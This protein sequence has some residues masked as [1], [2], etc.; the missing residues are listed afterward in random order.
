MSGHDVKGVAA[1]FIHQVLNPT[2]PADGSGRWRA[3]IPQFFFLAAGIGFYLVVRTFTEGAE[4]DAFRNAYSILAFEARLGL[5]LERG[6]Q[7]AVLHRSNV[8]AFFN[9]VY[10]FTFWPALVATMLYLWRSRP[11]QYLLY[12]D[13]MF[14]SGLIGLVVFA[15]YPVAP[16]RF[17]SGYVDTI[18]EA[19]SGA[20]P[21][22]AHPTG[23]TNPYAAV[24][25]FHVG[26]Y[27]LAAAALFL[28]FKGTAARWLAVVPPSIMAATVVV[29]A[30]HY[31]IDA[32]LGVFVCLSAL[33]ITAC[34]RNRG[35]S[36]STRPAD[37]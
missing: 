24:P 21:L 33:A 17:L 22:L 36:Q 2:V 7:D 3:F 30:N 19:A 1:R 11:R 26:W 12:R 4:E 10:T 5:D 27:A 14:V 25:S 37:A 13:A 34:V 15:V 29:T 18:N 8:V 20:S 28:A 31:V 6:V 9:W 23:V 32:I 35:T 16:P